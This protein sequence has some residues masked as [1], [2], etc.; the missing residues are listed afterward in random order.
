MI[1]QTLLAS[2]VK[3]EQQIIQIILIILFVE[4]FEKFTNKRKFLKK[5]DF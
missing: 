2:L 5:I 4:N 3:I 1:Y